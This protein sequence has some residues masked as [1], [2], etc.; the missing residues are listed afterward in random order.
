L[1]NV[2]GWFVLLALIRCLHFELPLSRNVETLYVHVYYLLSLSFKGKHVF[3]AIFP[4]FRCCATYDLYGP[5]TKKQVIP[6]Y[7]RA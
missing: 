2:L 5:V 4:Y 1:K 7:K 6:K 3:L